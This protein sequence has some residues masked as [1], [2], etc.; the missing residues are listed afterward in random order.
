MS[1]T[2]KKFNQLLQD[3]V[4]KPYEELLELAKMATAKAMDFF[5]QFDKEHN[6]A[7]M[8][9]PVIFTILASD[10]K[11]TALEYQFLKDLVG[12]VN[13]DN[14]KNNIQSFYSDEWETAVDELIDACSK[15]MKSNLLLLVTCVAAVDETITVDEQ[16]YIAKLLA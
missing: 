1:D 6:G 12:D 2:M 14:A 8:V 4:N 16:R 11:F 10:G 5:A 7:E 15:D 9:L 3:L 13:F